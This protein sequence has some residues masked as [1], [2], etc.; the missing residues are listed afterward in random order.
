[1]RIRLIMLGKTSRPELR[2]L[3]DAYVARI[4]RY[5]EIEI[6]EMR[7]TRKAFR[8][9]QFAPGAEVVLLNETGKQ[10]DSPQFATW[11]RSLQE[12]STRELVFLCGGAEGFP[13]HLRE[14]AGQLL[15]LSNLTM[16]HELARVVLVEQIYRAFTILAGH[17]YAK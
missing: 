9:V 3:V 10:L 6:Q 4:R 17:P 11:F 14:A 16:S 2:A 5:T 15:S 12:R 7:G 8:Q 1:M 13:E